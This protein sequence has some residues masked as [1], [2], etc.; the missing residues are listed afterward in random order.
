MSTSLK[1]PRSLGTSFHQDKSI[2]VFRDVGA[3]LDKHF[4]HDDPD[5]VILTRLAVRPCLV[6]GSSELVG[7]FLRRED[8]DFYNGLK[9]FF[10]GLFGHSILFAEGDEAVRL[11]KTLLPLF[12]GDSV[13]SYGQVIEAEAEKWTA[14]LTAGGGEEVVLYEEFKR[15]SMVVNLKV[16]LGVDAGD[17]PE[18][19]EAISAAATAHWHGIISVPLNVRLPMVASSSYRR[20]MEAKE[21][22]LEVI[23]S[24]LSLNQVDFLNRFKRA[25]D[26]DE[27]GI[28]RHVLIFVCALIPKAAASILTSLTDTAHLW[29]PRFVDA[30]TG[31]ISEESLCNVLREVIRLWPPFPGSLR[32]AKRNTQVGDFPV[33][34]GHAVFPATLAA[35]R[36]PAVFP[37]PDRFLPERWSTFNADDRDKLF[38]FGAGPHGCVGERF[39]CRFFMAV[40][41]RFLRDCT[42]DFGDP[43]KGQ[44]R[45]VKYLP[46]LRPTEL[47]KVWITKREQ[48]ESDS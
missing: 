6:L 2:E 33:P 4:K 47:E 11:R 14:R 26:M 43:N 5:R 10:F 24:R 22:L 3:F 1:K 41:Q 37:Y 46:V 44:E 21:Q 17:R 23:R 16:F 31:R 25:P 15:L 32:V 36:D 42:W 27:E 28:A 38:G 39:L 40:A 18:M 34:K 7:Q 12:D 19:M 29:Y 13:Q 20:A 8:D 35:H 48:P 45:K 30:H 9:D